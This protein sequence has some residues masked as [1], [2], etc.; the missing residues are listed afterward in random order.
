MTGVELPTAVAVGT[1]RAPVLIGTCVSETA[2]PLVALVLVAVDGRTG[3]LSKSFIS[4]RALGEAKLNVVPA[5][6]GVE[7]L[8]VELAAR[9]TS[10]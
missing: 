3:L 8:V 6:I 10:A 9:L 4:P 2:L 1:P 7:T 5:L